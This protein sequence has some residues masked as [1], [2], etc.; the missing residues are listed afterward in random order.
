[1]HMEMQRVNQVKIILNKNK[2]GGK[3]LGGV[4]NALCLDQAVLSRDPHVIKNSMSCWL[5]VYARCSVC[6]IC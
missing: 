2:V 3:L 5:E 4:S 1:M 6:V